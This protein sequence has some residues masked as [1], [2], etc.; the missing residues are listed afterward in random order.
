MARA[1]RDNEPTRWTAGEIRTLQEEAERLHDDRAILVGIIQRLLSGE[2]A[3]LGVDGRWYWGDGM[4]EPVLP[5]HIDGS[6]PGG[7]DTVFGVPS[8]HGRENFPPASGTDTPLV[9]SGEPDES[10]S[11]EKRQID[12]P[13]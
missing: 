4:T 5:A 9:A 10:D 1:L 11:S 12:G 3:L 7:G 6:M 8:R 2:R 13:E